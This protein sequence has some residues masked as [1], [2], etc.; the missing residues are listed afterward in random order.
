MGMNRETWPQGIGARR[1]LLAAWVN[2][3][4]A[5]MG[6]GGQTGGHAE[7]LGSSGAQGG[8]GGVPAGS[9]AAGGVSASGDEEPPLIIDPP[10]AA[11]ATDGAGSML[12]DAPGGEAG[13]VDYCGSSVLYTGVDRAVLGELGTCSPSNCATTGRVRSPF[14]ALVFDGDGK[15]V[16]IVEYMGSWQPPKEDWLA[17]AKD[18]RWQCH[19]NQ[20][21]EYCCIPAP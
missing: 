8:T 13:A 17:A 1:I 9:G 21:I 18:M 11:E 4:C 2:A 15:L 3:A 10:T 14:G 6:C 20:T 5:L 12:W 7:H 19:A 16:D